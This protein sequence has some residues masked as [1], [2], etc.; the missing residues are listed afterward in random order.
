M[1]LEDTRALT[2]GADPVNVFRL[3]LDADPPALR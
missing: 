1:S 3:V 2:P